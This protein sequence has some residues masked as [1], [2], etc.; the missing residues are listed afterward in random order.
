MGL[1]LCSSVVMDFVADVGAHCPVLLR[2]GDVYVLHGAAQY[3]WTHGIAERDHDTFYGHTLRRKTRIS[4]TLRKVLPELV[5]KTDL[6]SV[7]TGRAQEMET[8]TIETHVD[9]IAHFGDEP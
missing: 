3:Q 5:C 9:P 7:P 6:P 4:I 8:T 2:P 1:S